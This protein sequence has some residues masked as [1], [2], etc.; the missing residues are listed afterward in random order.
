[1]LRPAYGQE[2]GTASPW[3]NRTQHLT[4]KAQSCLCVRLLHISSTDPKKNLNTQHFKT[5]KLLARERSVEDG[6]SGSY[7]TTS[8]SGT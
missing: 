1:M 6:W 5:D 8:D 2:L 4:T 3:C 7:C